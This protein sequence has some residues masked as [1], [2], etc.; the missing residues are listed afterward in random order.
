MEA[1]CPNDGATLVETGRMGTSGCWSESRMD[2][3]VHVH[4]N[5]SPPVQ[6]AFIPV[7]PMAAAGHHE[8]EYVFTRTCPVCGLVQPYVREPDRVMDYARLGEREP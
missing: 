6:Y 1:T 8:A 3:E 7:P 5:V 4:D 2:H